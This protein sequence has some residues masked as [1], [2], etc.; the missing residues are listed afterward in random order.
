ML[1]SVY[2][3][4]AIAGEHAK[5]ATQKLICLTIS[6]IDK[7]WTTCQR[8]DLIWSGYDD[9]VIPPY[10]RDN[11]WADLLIP[12]AQQIPLAAYGSEDKHVLFAFDEAQDLFFAQ[13][14]SNK[15]FFIHD[16]NPQ[17]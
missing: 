17:Q 5:I 4:I 7:Q 3:G 9:D 16:I 6:C 1:Y 8:M 11:F 14:F 13:V 15:L 12:P 10:M 2:N